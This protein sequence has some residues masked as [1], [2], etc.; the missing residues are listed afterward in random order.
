MSGSKAK[1]ERA[2]VRK[3]MLEAM[4]GPAYWHGGPDGLKVGTELL[5]TTQLHQLPRDSRSRHVWYD[6]LDHGYVCATTDKVLAHDYAARWNL[7]M[8]ARF[9]QSISP[10]GSVPARNPWHNVPRTEGGTVYRVQPLGTLSHDP[11]YPEGVSFRMP[12]ARIIAVEE[13]GVP[14]SVKPSPEALRY[15]TW[16]TGERLWDDR[17]FAVAN[18]QMLNHGITSA[19]LGPLG[20]APD[21]DQILRFTN[22]ILAQRSQQR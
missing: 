6:D 12:R 15:P 3:E 20:Y 17:G 1:A 5:P 4:Q 14:F 22:Q 7:A 2:R 21:P 9:L 16:D 8:Q 11:D 10:T 19:D 13:A 18:E